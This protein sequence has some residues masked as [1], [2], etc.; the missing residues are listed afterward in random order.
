[1]SQAADKESVIYDVS[2]TLILF[3][4]LTLL[5]SERPKLYTILAFLSAIGLNNDMK[6]QYGYITVQNSFIL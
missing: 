3:L 2:E 6:Y 1:M 4:H 5:H